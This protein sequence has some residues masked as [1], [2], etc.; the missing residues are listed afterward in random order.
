MTTIRLFRPKLVNPV[1]A[2]WNDV[3]N[4]FFEND[5]RL[6][7]DYAASPKTNIIENADSYKVELS[8][9]GVSKSD[10]KIEVENDVLTISK[11]VKQDE[12][13]N[14]TFRLHEFRI[15][16]F[17]R[18]FTL[19]DHVNTEDIKADYNNGILSITLLKKEEAKPVKRAI[20]IE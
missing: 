12:D 2:S 1:A 6:D 7:T 4:T 17:E 9:P 18:K 16:A 19:P 10:I 14:M 13:E 11:S 20:N 15:G 3:L 8:V 5:N